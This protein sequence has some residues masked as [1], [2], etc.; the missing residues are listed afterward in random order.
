MTLRNELSVN[1]GLPSTPLTQN[2]ELFSEVQKIYNA[3]KA[4]ARAVDVYTGA[5]NEEESYWS[6]TAADRCLIG[7]NSRMY[8]EA[9]E[10]L[11]YGNLIGIKNDEKVWKAQDNV[12]RCFGFCTAPNGT[13]VGNVTEIQLLGLYPQFSPGTLTA[14]AF[15]Y[16]STT[17]GTPGASGTAPTWNQIIGFAITDTLLYFNPQY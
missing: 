15:Y 8:I 9:G 2:P 3:I 12:V 16:N 6:Q 1:L 13:T 11:S 14:G 4:L 10:N 17:A 5:L 7:L